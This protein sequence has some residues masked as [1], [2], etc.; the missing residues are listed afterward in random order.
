MT[1]KNVAFPQV[2]KNDEM[3][4]IAVIYWNHTEYFTCNSAH[5]G[6]TNWRGEKDSPYDAFNELEMCLGNGYRFVHTPACYEKDNERIAELE[7][8]IK[9]M[10]EHCPEGGCLVEV[11]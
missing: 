7:A 1:R 5:P 3:K 2:L 9:Q 10:K 6:Y 11:A 4:S 8:Q